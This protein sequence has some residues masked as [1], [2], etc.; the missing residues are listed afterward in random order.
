MRPIFG[1]GVNVLVHAVGRD[2]HA[3]DRLRREAL[4]QRLLER[5]HPEHAIGAGAGHRDADVG[6][7]LRH[8]H[9]DQRKA[10]GRMLEL[11]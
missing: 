8:E 7:A 4:L 6:A 9:A 2:R 10:R 1:G 5:L 3:L 11:L